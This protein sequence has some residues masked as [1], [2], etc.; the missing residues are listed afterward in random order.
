MKKP[1]ENQLNQAREATIK[2]QAGQDQ[3]NKRFKEDTQGN[4]N[5]GKRGL[6]KVSK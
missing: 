2:K 1:E 6:P 5:K 3:P 4:E